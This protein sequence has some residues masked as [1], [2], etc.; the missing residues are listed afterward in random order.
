MRLALKKALLFQLS[1]RS[2][3][4]NG[5]WWLRVSADTGLSLPVGVEGKEELIP[6]N[7]FLLGESRVVG[8]VC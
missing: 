4:C 5:K 7:V 3:C 8:E 6:D 2:G 1:P